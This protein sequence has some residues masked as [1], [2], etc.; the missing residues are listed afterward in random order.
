MEALAFLAFLYAR[1]H[2][3]TGAGGV[4]ALV[5]ARIYGADDVPQPPTFPFVSIALV[6]GI[7][8]NT[9][10]GV[11]VLHEL[12]ALVKVQGRGKDTAPLDAIAA[13]VEAVLQKASGSARG[14]SIKDCVRVGVD[15]LPADTVGSEQYRAITQRFRGWV[16]AA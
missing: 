8:R 12:I 1:L 13:R 10:S 16:Q 15:I 3:D 4:S 11:R 5:A 9:A 2:A 7:D 6:P 14:L